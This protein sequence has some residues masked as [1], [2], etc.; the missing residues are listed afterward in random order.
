MIKEKILTYFQYMVQHEKSA[1]TLALSI[2]I[3]VFIAFSPYLFF[4]TIMIFVL[5]W[6]LKLNPVITFAVTYAINNPWTMCFV[7]FA[8]YL[9]GDFVLRMSL[10]SPALMNPSWMNWVNGQLCAYTGLSGLSFWSFMVGGNL[11]G[12]LFGVMLYPI[13]KNM[14]IRMNKNVHEAL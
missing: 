2:S 3:G 10:C 13:M 8:D 14:C 1:H 7:Y 6:F 4:H 9:V 12:V 5:S 11:L